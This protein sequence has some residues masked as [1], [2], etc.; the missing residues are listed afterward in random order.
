MWIVPTFT[1][2]NTIAM[3]TGFFVICFIIAGFAIYAS[4]RA[5]SHV[6]QQDEDSNLSPKQNVFW[7]SKT[8]AVL[9]PNADNTLRCKLIL[10]D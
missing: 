6:K 2:S 1:L 4:E 3:K 7:A 5:K 8:N 10:L 9:P